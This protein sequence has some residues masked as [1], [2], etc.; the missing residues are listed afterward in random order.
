ME[1]TTNFCAS[2]GK[3]L[4]ETQVF[5]PEC[6]HPATPPAPPAEP[7]PEAP[8]EAAPEA[9]K[10]KKKKVGLI[11]GLVAG[12]TVGL[13]AL[14]LAIILIIGVITVGVG[15]LLGFLGLSA[16]VNANKGPDFGDIYAEHCSY[17]WADLAS[18]ESYLYVD[19]NPYNWD[20]DGVA[21]MDAYYAIQDINDELGLPSYVFQDMISTTSLDGLQTMSFPD[22]GVT[23]S[24]RY[25]PD[26]GL[27]VTYKK[28]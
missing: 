10:K 17:I 23:V 13:G 28:Y 27:E 15:G 8:V 22:Q 6:G 5:C 2:C 4:E 9:P 20:D 12:G 11:I 21:Y 18:D 25:H 19:T 24:W 16:L 3:E 14:V 7:A 1:N 26:R